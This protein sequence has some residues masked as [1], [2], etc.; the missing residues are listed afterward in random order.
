MK[1]VR[2]GDLGR[3]K[4]YMYKKFRNYLDVKPRLSKVLGWVFIIFGI[5]G[6]ILPLI[7]GAVFFFIGLELLGIRLLFLDRWL[8]RDKK[9]ETAPVQINTKAEVV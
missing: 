6:V 7:P 9:E 1:I 8:K 2:K 4:E 3:Q 5:L